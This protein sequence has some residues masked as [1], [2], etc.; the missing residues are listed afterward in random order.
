MPYL[1]ALIALFCWSGSDLFS[2]IGSRPEDKQSHWKM[3]FV[4]GAV[5]GL[6]ALL[7]LTV[8]AFEFDE[9]ERSLKV[10]KVS[11]EMADLLAYLPIS[12]LYIS[13]MIL[14]YVGLRYIELSVSSPICNSSG[15]LAALLCLI[16]LPNQTLAPLEIAGIVLVCAGVIALGFV[17]SSESEE[18]KEL[19]QKESNIKYTKSFIALL[20]PLL[21]LFLDALGTFADS[22]VLN[23]GINI[24]EE[25]TALVAYELTFAFMALAAFV[26]LLI[27][28]EKVNFKADSPKGVAALFETVGQIAYVFALAANPV[29]SAPIISAYCVLSVVWSR[30]FLKEK[31]SPKHYLTITIAV[32]GIILLGVAEG[33][34]EL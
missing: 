22:Y 6:H 21:Y 10:V 30:I 18:L 23:S 7:S 20:F 3:V 25:N 5:M 4:V 28:K 29:V 15:A 2:K 32:A 12:M 14:G 17:Q 1:Y 24:L 26:F 8:G 27:K 16:F 13:S 34:A 19:R 33:L 11:F 31:L 9:T